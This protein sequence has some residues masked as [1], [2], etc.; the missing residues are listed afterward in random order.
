MAEACLTTWFSVRWWGLAAA[1]RFA[2]SSTQDIGAD[3]AENWA[4]TRF[5]DQLKPSLVKFGSQ[6]SRSQLLQRIPESPD[7]LSPNR[8][9]HCDNCEITQREREP[10]VLRDLGL[11]VFLFFCLVL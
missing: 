8:S 1:S 6:G 5:H 3:I 7:V 4:A 10:A 9:R 11:C 2:D